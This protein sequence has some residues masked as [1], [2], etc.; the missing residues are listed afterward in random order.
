MSSTEEI[1]ERIRASSRPVARKQKKEW[2]RPTPDDF[3]SGSVLAFDPSL[4]NTGW[5]MLVRPLPLAS[6]VV[7]LFTGVCSPPPTD[8]GSDAMTLWRAHQIGLLIHQV[9]GDYGVGRVSAIAHEMPTTSGQR[10]ES[11]LMASREVQRAA[12]TLCP[13]IPLS[14]VYVRHIHATLLPP[15]QR[16]KAHTKAHTK[17][18]VLRY[19]DISMLPAGSKLNE[20]VYDGMSVGLT[21]LYDQKR[22]S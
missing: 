8:L 3:D 21:H 6:K 18:A 4:T 12:L 20:H 11:S 7:A 1:L 2:V 9:V 19:V 15:E 14:P 5:V 17:E 10:M 22:A 13:D 16:G